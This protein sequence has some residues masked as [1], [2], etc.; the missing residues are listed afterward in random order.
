MRN[1][2][3]YTNVL[4]N[5]RSVSVDDC[6]RWQRWLLRWSGNADRESD[7]WVQDILRRTMEDELRVDISSDMLDLEQEERGAVTMFRLI[8]ERM[9]VRNQEA[10][11]SMIGYITGFDIRM[12]D[13]ESVTT[14]VLRIEAALRPHAR[15]YDY[16]VGLFRRRA[17]V[18]ART[19]GVQLLCDE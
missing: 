13:G 6:K 5:W 19:T 2:R 1:A 17:D 15:L 10:H 16:A 11:D 4:K 18:V 7:A 9:V 8:V 12:F 14:A 3:S